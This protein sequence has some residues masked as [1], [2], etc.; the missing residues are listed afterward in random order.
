MIKMKKVN[1]K[2]IVELLKSLHIITEIQHN[3]SS[4][5]MSCLLRPYELDK[6]KK[7]DATMN[8]S[9]LLFTFNP[10]GYQP[11]GLFHALLGFLLTLQKKF[12][13]HEQR[14]RN[15]VT[16]FFG[17]VNVEIFSTPSN[18]EI[19]VTKADKEKCLEVKK[20][21]S[22]QIHAIM[23]EM[24]HMKSNELGIAFYCPKSLTS[25]PSSSPHIAKYEMLAAEVSPRAILRCYEDKCEDHLLPIELEDKHNIWFEV[26]NNQSCVSLSYTLIL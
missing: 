4:L 6:L 7:I 24:Q 12:S 20:L 1:A 13:L 15:R 19:R 2:T 18:L 21:L 26:C 8:P 9:P 14:Y 23:K 11:V 5:F 22:D 16:L 25:G 17:D 10:S 3:G